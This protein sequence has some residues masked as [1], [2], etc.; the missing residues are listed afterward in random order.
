[1][2]QNEYTIGRSDGF[3]YIEENSRKSFAHCVSISPS[4]SMSKGKQT[5]HDNPMLYEGSSETGLGDF[6]GVVK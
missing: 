6:N 4:Y 1:M 3:Y 2:N 5:Q